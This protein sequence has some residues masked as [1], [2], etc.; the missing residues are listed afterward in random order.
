VSKTFQIP[1]ILDGISPLK[2]GGL[3]MRFHT[4][5]VTDSEKLIALSFYQKFGWLLFQEQEH[6]DSLELESV[7]R[8][9]G[10]K[11]PSQ[12]LR[13]VLYILYQQ[14]G[15]TDQT[16]EQFYATQMEKFINRVKENLA[17]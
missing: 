9:T 12:R 7:R 16:F 17:D 8:D 5:E 6:D 13:S 1:S 2:D 11:T 3:S 4:N 15:K 10:G 14:S